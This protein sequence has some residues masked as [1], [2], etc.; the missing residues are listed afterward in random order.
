[1]T[2]EFPD[3]PHRLILDGR[4][5]LSVTGVTEVAGFD[6]TAVILKIQE[7]ILSVQGKD[8]KMLSLDGGQV[9][10]E[11]TVS[12]LIYE[13]PRQSGGLRRRLLG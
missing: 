3:L 8:L 5:K 7:G 1:M 11:G 12:A 4:R 9:T 10:V 2:E 6:E 13:I